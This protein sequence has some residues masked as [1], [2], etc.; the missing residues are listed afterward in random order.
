ML[1]GKNSSNFN[2]KSNLL[3]ALTA[4]LAILYFLSFTK[5]CSIQQQDKREKLKTALVNQKYKDSISYITLQDSTGNLELHN[6]NGFWTLQRLSDYVS[7]QVTEPASVPVSP[8][9]INSFLNELIKVRNLYKISDKITKN[10]SLG[11]SNGTEF[12]IGY[13]VSTPDTA[14][15]GKESFYELIFG[16]QDFS[17]TSR[18]MM[19]GENPQVYEIDDSLDPYLTTSIQSWAEPYII[20]RIAA[21]TKD[22]QSITVFKTDSKSY[23]LTDTSKLLELRHG[24]LPSLSEYEE[25]NDKSALCTIQIENGDKTSEVLKIYKSDNQNE[26]SYIVKVLYKNAA[27]NTSYTSCS[28][29]SGWTYNKII[30]TTL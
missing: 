9:R 6:Y 28:K 2:K 25:L 15:E 13:A 10:S 11:L 26:N 23:K 19:S 1:N 12:H 30:E 29:I 20:S 5:N 24:G 17:L 8:E 27:G 16:N 3:I 4:F 7:S 21:N 22:I 18:Y 14:S